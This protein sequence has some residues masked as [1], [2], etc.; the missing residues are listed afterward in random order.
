MLLPPGTDSH[1]FDP[2][3]SDMLKLNNAD[4]FVYTGKYMEP[5]AE[6]IVAGLDNKRLKVLDASQGIT[7]SKGHHHDDDD[8]DKPK[9]KKK[10]QEEVFLIF[11]P[12]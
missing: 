6:R 12:W 8:D 5:W 11:H 7:L 4:I 3:P 10:Q 9:K 2:R 1:S